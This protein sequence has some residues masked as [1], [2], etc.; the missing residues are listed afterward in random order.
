VTVSTPSWPSTP[1]DLQLSDETDSDASSPYGP[2][3]RQRAEI[4][5]R[6]R[7]HDAKLTAPA[8]PLQLEPGLRWTP[9]LMDANR[10]LHLE[11][12]DHIPTAFVRRLRAAAAAGRSVLVATR[13]E[14]LTF[15]T[16]EFLQQLDVAPFELR[17]DDQ[18]RWQVSGWSSVADWVA[19][20]NMALRPEELR[21]LVAQRL[22]AADDFTHRTNVARGTAYEEA[23]CLVF[24]QVSWLK[25]V[26]HAYRNATEEID[27]AMLVTGAGEYARLANGPIAIATAKNENKSLASAT[28][29]YLQQQM[30]NRRGR[31][32]LGFAC[33]RGQ[34]SKSAQLE[35]LRSSQ[36]DLLIVPIGETEFQGL[37]DDAERLDERLAEFVIAATMA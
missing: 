5:D 22:T 36:T 4:I 35:I 29:K 3:D 25:V 33:A 9:D 18:R 11:L 32:K 30:A 28:I 1:T 14:S 24:S 10:V 12:G 31:A 15:E 2:D 26:E 34:V 8:N 21:K 19:R 7:D 17:Q 23:L 27:I 37:L 20:G 16:L 6:L 13:A